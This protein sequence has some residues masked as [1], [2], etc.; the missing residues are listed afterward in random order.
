MWE[1]RPQ[2]AHSEQYSLILANRRPLTQLAL[3]A[4]TALGSLLR[5]NCMDSNGF[6][7]NR[8]H[9]KSYFKKLK[10]TNNLNNL[11]NC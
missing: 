9:I 3:P 2:L 1:R 6:K 5:N 8:Y 11:K 10:K 7:M 4:A